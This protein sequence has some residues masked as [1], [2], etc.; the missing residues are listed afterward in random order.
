M[1]KLVSILML[2][3]SS[4]IS[5]AQADS[6]TIR[7]KSIEDKSLRT[8]CNL[9][10]IQIRDIFCEDTLL[11]GKVFNVIIKEFKKGKVHSSINLDIKAG[12]VQIPILVGGDSMIYEIDY[13]EKAGFGDATKSLSVTFAGILK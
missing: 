7:F 6:T 1:K 9:T 13:T 12:I 2:L 4:S 11:K 8:I 3:V 10:G 5:F